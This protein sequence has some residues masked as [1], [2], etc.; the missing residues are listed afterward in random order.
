MPFMLRKGRRLARSIPPKPYPGPWPITYWR[1]VSNDG[2]TLTL[3]EERK[4]DLT[5]S[6]LAKR[7]A[8]AVELLRDVIPLPLAGEGA[9]AGERK[10][11]L[12][13]RDAEMWLI[14]F[15]TES[16]HFPVAGNKGLRHLADLLSRPYRPL[17][18]LDLQGLSGGSSRPEHSFQEVDDDEAMATMK[19]EARD[20]AGRIEKA[21]RD[22]N[23]PEVNRLMGDLE[24]LTQEILRSRGLGSRKRRLGSTSPEVKAF[25]AVDCNIKRCYKRM[26][27]QFPNLV[28]HL[29]RTIRATSPAFMYIPSYDPLQLNPDWH[30]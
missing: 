21:R 14:Q 17:S 3:T 15:G 13:R 2:E 29:Q 11:F 12:F 28:S 22:N 7:L 20:F 26:Q 8:V 27:K 23:I 24:T 9:D 19:K 30:F 25:E 10:Q 1:P 16:G 5:L 4:A 18:G 6:V